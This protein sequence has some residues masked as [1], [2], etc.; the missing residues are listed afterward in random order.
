MFQDTYTSEND[1]SFE[2]SSTSHIDL[3][4]SMI[5]KCGVKVKDIV[6]DNN[7]VY[8]IPLN[9]RDLLAKKQFLVNIGLIIE[10][11][12]IREK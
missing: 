10:G 4:V 6:S 3:I 11:N 2:V 9:T 12:K 8:Y 1:D 7:I 5:E